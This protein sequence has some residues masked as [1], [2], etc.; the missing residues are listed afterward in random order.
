M[1]V[2]AAD[3]ALINPRAVR[4]QPDLPPP[5]PAD[6]QPGPA[7]HGFGRP[8]NTAVFDFVLKTRTSPDSAT[9]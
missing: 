1:T 7:A 6:R 8:F 2:P 5:R 9:V 4:R 3:P